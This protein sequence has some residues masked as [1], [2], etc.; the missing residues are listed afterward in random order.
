MA[1]MVCRKYELHVDDATG[2]PVSCQL[3]SSKSSTVHEVLGSNCRGRIAA[4]AVTYCCFCSLWIGPS[5]DGV[6]LDCANTTGI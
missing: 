3:T 1:A 6:L 4:K 5:G 2:Y